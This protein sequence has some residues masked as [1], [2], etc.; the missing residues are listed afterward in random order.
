MR[1]IY[2]C[3]VLLLM[4]AVLEAR[5]YKPA[6]SLTADHSTSAVELYASACYGFM[7]MAD[8]SLT[9]DNR[10]IRSR[11]LWL[12][13]GA[14]YKILPCVKV[15]IDVLFNPKTTVYD[16]TVKSDAAK[17]RRVRSWSF[18]PLAYYSPLNQF[19][20]LRDF[21]WF[22]FWIVGGLRADYY[23]LYGN[24]REKIKQP[25][26]MSVVLGLQF[27]AK[28]VEYCRFYIRTTYDE[29]LALGLYR[30]DESTGNA[31]ISFQIAFNAGFC[32]TFPCKAVIQKRQFERRGN[33][34]YLK[35]KRQL[36][37]QPY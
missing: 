27:D 36:G 7:S 23:K 28:L 34:Y 8:Y 4:A 11:D 19:L 3:S 29:K 22:D 6:F 5:T 15:G 25:W 16:G 21:D 24:E 33:Y 10:K 37:N 30:I 2:L 9:V 18:G 32:V 26:G 12:N 14:N 35:N 17:F 1:K 31:P 20:P 13:A